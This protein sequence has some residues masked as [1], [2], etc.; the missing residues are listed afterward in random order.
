MSPSLQASNPVSNTNPTQE[1]AR[2]D[3]K[4]VSAN[5]QAS[6][7]TQSLES[8]NGRATSFMDQTVGT[9]N[10]S[11]PSSTTIGTKLNQNRTQVAV[12]KSNFEIKR[13]GDISTLT[14]DKISLRY[15]HKAQQFKLNLDTNVAFEFDKDIVRPGGQE[16]LKQF[17]S[18]VKN[19]QSFCRE[20]G[21]PMPQIE[22]AGHTDSKGS[23][24]FNQDLSERRSTQV[25]KALVAEGVS[26]DSLQTKGY[27]EK[28][29]IAANEIGTKDNPQG[30]AQNR[31]VEAG[32][33]LEERHFESLASYLR[34]KSIVV[35]KDPPVNSGGALGGLPPSQQGQ[36]G[37]SGGINLS[38][39]KQET[40]RGSS[41]SVG[42]NAMGSHSNSR[43]GQ[44]SASAGIAQGSGSLRSNEELRGE[45][46]GFISQ[47]NVAGTRNLTFAS[48]EGVSPELLKE[49]QEKHQ[50]ALSS[51]FQK[52]NG[53]V[54][55]SSKED[56]VVKVAQNAAGETSLH[57]YKPGGFFS[58]PDWNN[59]LARFDYKADGSLQASVNGSEQAKKF[60]LSTIERDCIN[61][62]LSVH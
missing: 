46:T 56:V 50:A 37:F 12:D 28:S 26:P 22:I 24:Q 11:A 20:N 52:N 30:R 49:F 34:E 21:V 25:A 57:L 61:S 58:Q 14:T 42:F 48:A 6:L 53:E 1:R 59:T 32:I 41:D 16:A 29:P 35:I 60:D 44:F 5:E 9:Q 8:T 39:G 13:E 7:R 33:S 19:I 10:G 62:A 4:A 2:G 43:A 51:S 47:P 18:Q 40:M 54:F 3:F 27:G 38:S 45:A 23:D 15:D 17:A 31:R 36:T 55:L